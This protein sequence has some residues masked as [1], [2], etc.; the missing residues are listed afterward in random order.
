VTWGDFKA[1]VGARGVTDDMDI[2]YIDISTAPYNDNIVIH[3]DRP[4]Q[5]PPSFDIS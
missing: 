1:W 4:D 2:G 5:L 3:R